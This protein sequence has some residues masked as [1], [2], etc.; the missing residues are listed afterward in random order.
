MQCLD[1][2]W[3]SSEGPFVNQ[4]EEKLSEKVTRKYETCLMA[5]QP[6]YSCSSSEDWI[7]MSYCHLLLLFLAPIQL[8][9]REKPIVVDA[10]SESWNMRTDLIED[11]ITQ[12]QS[13]L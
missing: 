7:V 12:K 10:D 5:V 3:I 9:E 11:K 8:L 13:L 6:R 1:T 4:F 2:G